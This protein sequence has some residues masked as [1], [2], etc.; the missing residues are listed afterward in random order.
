MDAQWKCPPSA[1]VLLSRRL[2]STN[3]GPR[4]KQMKAVYTDWVTVGGYDSILELFVFKDLQGA[5]EIFRQDNTAYWPIRFAAMTMLH[6]QHKHGT[7]S[8]LL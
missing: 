1:I 8:S 4:L 3:L 5:Q 6:V 2:P 7:V